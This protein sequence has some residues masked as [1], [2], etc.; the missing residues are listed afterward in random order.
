[1]PSISKV[2]FTN[3]IY[4][5]GNKRYIDT[6]F[7]FDGYNGILLLE[8]GAGKTVF[9]Q[10]LIQAVLP[11]KTVAQR[12]IQET[13][14][15]SNN[16]AHI[17][18]EWILDERPRRYALT[19]VSLF[20][21]SREQLASQQFAMEYS[22]DARDTLD[23][24]PFTRREGEKERPATRE[25]MAA[26][27]RGLAER[28]MV[29]RFF[30]ESDTLLAYQKYIEEHFKI[31]PTEW[32][33]IATINAAEGGVEAYF[34]NCRTTAELIDRMLLPTVEEACAAGMG[35]VD[36][37]GFADLFVKQRD[38]FKQQIRLQKR[39]EEMQGVLRELGSYTDVRRL[40]AE[41]EEQLLETNRRLKA[42]YEQVLQLDTDRKEEQSELI[43]RQ[44]G[45]EMAKRYNAQQEMACRVAIA[46]ENY[47]KKREDQEKAQ[48]ILQE[49]DGKQRRNQERLDNIKYAGLKVA[50]G[51]TRQL[52]RAHADA[53]AAL[54]EDAETCELEKQLLQNSGK[55][56][57][58]F[59]REGNTYQ[60]DLQN[61]EIQDE[62]ICVKINEKQAELHEN[63]NSVHQIERQLGVCSGEIKN[64]VEQEEYLEGSLFPDTL[65]IDPKIQQI[66]WENEQKQQQEQCDNYQKN[67]AFY[68]EQQKTLSLILPK[69][70][71]EKQGIQQDEQAL[72]AQV[73]VITSNGQ[74]LL[75]R[76]QQQ[77]ACANIAIDALTLYQ[78][79]EFFLNQL[80][81]DIILL[82]EQQKTIFQRYRLAH[83]QLD[84]YGQV[85]EFHA[86]PQLEEKL[87]RISADVAFL[88]SGAEVFRQ[89]CRVHGDA[90]GDIYKKYPFWAASVVTSADTIEMVQ[91]KLETMADELTQPIF[92]LTEQELRAIFDGEETF[93]NRQVIPAF[94]R[95]IIPAEFK[96]WLQMLRESALVVDNERQEIEVRIGALKSLHMDLQRFFRKTPFSE[97]QE[98]LSSRRSLQEKEQVLTRNILQTEQDLETCRVNLEKYRKTLYSAG[99]RLTELEQK[100]AEV[101][102][103][104][105]LQKKHLEILSRQE[106]LSANLSKLQT[107]GQNIQQAIEKLREAKAGLAER[108]GECREGLRQL[109]NKLYYQEVQDA[110][111]EVSED[112]YETLVQMRIRIQT[113]LDGCNENRGRLE[114]EYQAAKKEEKRCG[115]ELRAL[116]LSAEGI[117]NEQFIYP[118]N[119]EQEIIRLGSARKILQTEYRDARAAWETKK[120]AQDTSYGAWEAEKKHYDEQYD[121][122]LT[123][124]GDL[125]ACKAALFSE[126]KELSQQLLQVRK[127]II[128]VTE[129]LTNLQKLQQNLDRKNERLAFAVDAVIPVLLEEDLRTV[130]SAKLAMLIEPKLRAAENLYGK[131]EKSREESQKKKDS[132][133]RYC[134]GK[135]CEESMRRRVVDGIRMKEAYEEFVNW[136]RVITSNIHQI[137]GLAESERKEHYMHIEHMISHMTLY[138]RDICNGLSEIA[139]KT[140]IKVEDTFKD[141]Y[142]IHMPVWNDSDARTAIRSYLDYITKKLDLPEYQD[143]MGHE[144]G[145]KIR[146]GLKKLLRTQQII[147][148]VLG[149]NAIKVK[150]RKATSAQLFSDRPYSWEE[151]N[152]WSGG[153]MWSKNMA[154]FLGCLNYLSE[155]RCHI[156]RGKYLNRVVIADNPFGKAS[157]DH[158]LN[159]VFFIAQQLGFQIIALTAHE[160]GNF[161]RKYFPVMYSC[162]FADIAG[163]KGKILCP[164]KEIK[165]AFFE[166]HNPESLNRLKDYEEIGLF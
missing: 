157:S 152:K 160:D 135:I 81:D 96:T 15:L 90:A 129:E 38:H 121:E 97:Y 33:K 119:G 56:R 34:E 98:I 46:W 59:L 132:F 154:L 116:Q 36:G 55:L 39:I 128:A 114:S 54:A 137:I 23:T 42:L 108:I 86:D 110:E 3:V 106:S 109:K 113:R 130:N 61:M 94:W 122:L 71:A 163:Q 145:N 92:L 75:D 31:I 63:G 162:R 165:T 147:N 158:V 29:A 37:N 127:N 77:P 161:I 9:V 6:T 35:I 41:A 74:E 53:L 52:I 22:S 8:N 62:K 104:F 58:W 151:S 17:A 25:E 30:S 150:C 131:V 156:K 101:G 73:A 32:N 57:D 149:E 60:Q 14:Q 88:K 76:L 18:I 141:I 89:Y 69:Q 111:R 4:D 166:E 65:H 146:E 48:G 136:N 118:I 153:E 125:S 126:K 79:A 115:D 40:Q 99:Q 21:N 91:Q 5:N 112:S 84:M 140:R 138:L 82:E 1:M 139:A 144:D 133:I 47:A 7:Q 51:Q 49:A 85:E 124:T 164:E 93:P 16:V 78:R 28:S 123:F 143:D 24:L 64:I 68:E 134:E 95:N 12:K 100:L 44:D 19:A 72:S 117:L 120:Q 2:R 20:I 102:M 80:G 50:L 67:I 66:A 70:R 43:E 10:T 103:Y 13:L 83:Q 27:F 26:Y 107:G 155:K 159:P 11:H 105:S 148:R 45:L 87:E 142:N